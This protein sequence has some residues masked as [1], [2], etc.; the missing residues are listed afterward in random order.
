MGLAES[1]R[2][3]VMS[4]RPGTVLAISADRFD[5]VFEGR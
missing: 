2:A 5:P 3:L 1:E 4:P